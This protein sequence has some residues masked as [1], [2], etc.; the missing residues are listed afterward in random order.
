MRNRTT[1]MRIGKNRKRKD[2]RFVV[3][4]PGGIIKNPKIILAGD[5]FQVNDVVIL[6][7]GKLMPMF[8]EDQE[9]F[10]IVAAIGKKGYPCLVAALEGK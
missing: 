9:L 3:Q 7:D 6:E 4:L 5:D 1:K 8:S 2:K 10:G